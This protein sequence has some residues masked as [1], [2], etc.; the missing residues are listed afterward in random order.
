MIV[1]SS[2]WTD[3]NDTIKYQDSK[4]YCMISS[5]CFIDIPKPDNLNKEYGDERV[6]VKLTNDNKS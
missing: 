5:G 1:N 3:Y 6:I 2:D 4:Y